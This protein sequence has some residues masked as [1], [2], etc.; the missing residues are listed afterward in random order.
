MS[1]KPKGR[2]DRTRKSLGLDDVRSVKRE[3]RRAAKGQRAARIA[4][5]RLEKM[6]G[7]K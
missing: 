6:G 1:D 4:R 5:N 2:H 7:R 3:V